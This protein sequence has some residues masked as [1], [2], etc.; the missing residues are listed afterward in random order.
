MDKNWKNLSRIL[1]NLQVTISYRYNDVKFTRFLLCYTKRY[2]KFFVLILTKNFVH[3]TD[4]DYDLIKKDD[5]LQFSEEES[6][7]KKLAGGRTD[8]YIT[9]SSGSITFFMKDE[10]YHFIFEESAESVDDL[11][12]LDDVMYD[13]SAGRKIVEETQELSETHFSDSD[14]EEMTNQTFENNSVPNEPQLST[15]PQ[16]PIVTSPAQTR[17]VSSTFVN[18]NIESEEQTNTI[19]INHE[20]EDESDGD[21]SGDDSGDEQIDVGI[22]GFEDPMQKTILPPDE[23][24]FQNIILGDTYYTFSLN[25]LKIYETTESLE[26]FLIEKEK[27]IHSHLENYMDNYFS[28]IKSMFERIQKSISNKKEEIGKEY[29]LMSRKQAMLSENMTKALKLSKGKGQ[30]TQEAKLLQV[31]IQHTIHNLST[32]FKKKYHDYREFFVNVHES[33]RLL[34]TL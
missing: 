12:E 34:E 1:N 11:D 10:H 4:G 25:D 22:E 33:L 20:S 7:L 5:T 23:Q 15:V 13:F 16:Q 14:N 30:I 17:P 6:F 31:E 27:I 18:R 3:L 32:D 19:E 28:S 2:K 9:I 24:S 26:S 8:K 21:K 29:K